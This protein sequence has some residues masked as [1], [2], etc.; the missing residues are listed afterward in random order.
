M[1][2]APLSLALLLA[3]P[4]FAQ[5]QGDIEAR[6]NSCMAGIDMDALSRRA[7]GF[8]AAHD[9]Q[10]RVDE[11]CAAGDN[12]GAFAFADG[13]E[14]AFY[15]SDAEG[16]KMKACLNDILGSDISATPDDICDQ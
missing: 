2:L 11:L 4:A 1:R 13:V 15:A 5:E 6:M 14:K 12:E 8:A 9:Y 7:E 10:A 16:A 3:A